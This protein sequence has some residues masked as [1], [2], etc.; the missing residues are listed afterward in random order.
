MATPVRRPLAYHGPMSN[1]AHEGNEPLASEAALRAHADE[2][3][4]LAA[5]Y[6]ISELRIAGAGRLVG[7]IAD[8]RDLFDIA[9]FETAA[10]DLVGAEVEV[11][12]EGVL[13]NDNVSPDLLAA[14]PL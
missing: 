8:D 10:T 9:H 2:L 4:S 13:G 11:F 7:R 3:Q 14:T 1:T 12:S 6:G 5:Q